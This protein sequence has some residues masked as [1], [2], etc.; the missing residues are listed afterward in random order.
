MHKFEG[1]S[2]QQVLES[3]REV[4]KLGPVAKLKVARERALAEKSRQSYIKQNPSDIIETDFTRANELESKLR[5]TSL[6]NS[7]EKD[8]KGYEELEHDGLGLSEYAESYLTQYME[9]K[10]KDTMKK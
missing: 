2:D 7:M 10:Y 6:E 8:W 4:T 3:L 1:Y 5:F 9:Q